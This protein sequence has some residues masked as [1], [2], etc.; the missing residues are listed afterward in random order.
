MVKI[1]SKN[2][3]LGEIDNVSLTPIKSCTN[4]KQCSKNCYALKSYRMFPN[5]K[6]AWDHNFK[7]AK[8]NRAAYFKGINDY[9]RKKQPKLFR[10]HVAGDILDQAY[11]ESMKAIARFNP[12]TKF[13]AFTKNYNIKFYAIPKNLSII[14][15]AWPGLPLPKKNLPIAFY[16]DGTENRVKNAIECFGKCDSCGMCWSLKMLGKNVVFHKH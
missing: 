3:K 16:Q 7:L 4:C 1:S 2:S 14:L 5:V 6:N 9:I 13:L 10:W 8:T 12:N 11:F 15:S